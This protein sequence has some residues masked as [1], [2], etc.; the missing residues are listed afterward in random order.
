MKKNI[1]LLCIVFACIAM[2]V[3]PASA[4]KP[5]DPVATLQDQINALALRVSAL[6]SKVTGII[7][8]ITD[9]QTQ[10]ATLN[11]KVNNIPAAP[12]FVKSPGPVP[13]GTVV[14]VPTGYTTSQCDIIVRP[15]YDDE[16][17]SYKSL[18]GK[19]VTATTMAFYA[20]PNIGGTDSSWTIKS[21]VN[22]M[23]ANDDIPAPLPK[24]PLIYYTII[25][26]V[27]T[28]Y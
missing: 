28:N 2:L 7:T 21:T 26:P 27:T 5:V 16:G 13:H 9:F 1:V 3:L 17:F 19:L 12:V 4:G 11:T 22:Y 14:N 10:I 6:E 8:S 15:D 25:C 18:D 20:D 24:H 23:Y